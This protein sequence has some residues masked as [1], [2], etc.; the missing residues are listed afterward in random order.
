MDEGHIALEAA[1]KSTRI[2]DDLLSQ[3][4]VQHGPTHLSVSLIVLRLQSNETESHMHSQHYVFKPSTA[5]A[6]PVL[7]GNWPNIAPASVSLAYRSCRSHG[8]W[9]T[10]F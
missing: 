8:I 1:T 10:G 4:L 3:N 5:A 9:K 7:Q 6:Q 2:I